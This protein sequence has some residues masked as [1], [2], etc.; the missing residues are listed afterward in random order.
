M[1]V[2]CL[3][4]TRRSL[5]ELFHC[6]GWD[7]TRRYVVWQ[8]RHLGPHVRLYWGCGCSTLLADADLPRRESRVAR[9]TLTEAIG[10]HF[11]LLWELLL[12]RP[13]AHDRVMLCYIMLHVACASGLTYAMLCYTLHRALPPHLQILHNPPCSANKS[14]ERSLK[15]CAHTTRV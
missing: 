1:T 2:G 7:E 8:S 13:S 9:P 3:K 6:R 15:A 5:L 4:V 14:N 12:P 11:T 10:H